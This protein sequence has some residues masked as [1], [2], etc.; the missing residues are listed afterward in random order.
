MAIPLQMDIFPFT[1]GR[2]NMEREWRKPQSAC[3]G[4]DLEFESQ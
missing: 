2:C 3:K 1:V 4:V